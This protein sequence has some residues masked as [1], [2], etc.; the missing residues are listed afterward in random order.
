MVKASK[1]A[2]THNWLAELLT[3]PYRH[4]N[5]GETKVGKTHMAVRAIKELGGLAIDTEGRWS[6]LDVP[7]VELSEVTKIAKATNRDWVRLRT[8]L[9]GRVIYMPA[10]DYGLALRIAR[11]LG[12]ARQALTAPLVPLI[13]FDGWTEFQS[14]AITNLGAELQG[15]SGGSDDP[16]VLSQRGWG[17]LYREQLALQ[18]ALDP[19]ETG[20]L[21]YATANVA[22][23][24]DPIDRAISYLAPDLSGQFG[25]KI[26]KHYDLITY[27]RKVRP[28]KKDDAVVRRIYFQA[29]GN[30]IAGHIWEHLD[31]LPNSL[32]NPDL[33][34]ILEK[35]AAT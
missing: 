13:V 31:V 17:V 7:T 25:A 15:T 4:L 20:S 34:D 10:D 8:L 18:V 5:Y 12:E 22:E 24:D 2:P 23:K 16:R 32:D 28:E 29:V 27:M 19:T 6:A 11:L 35:L 9:A 3:H 1:G 33:C 21:L 26:K 14:K 30:F